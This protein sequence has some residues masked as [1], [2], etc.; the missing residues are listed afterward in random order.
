VPATAAPGSTIAI[1]ASAVDTRG[2]VSS[3]QTINVTVLDGTPPSVSITGVTTGERVRPGQEVTA[4]VSAGDAG[5]IATIGFSASGAAPR[6][7][8]RGRADSTTFIRTSVIYQ[9]FSPDFRVGK[10][11]Q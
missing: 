11:S 4:V 5:G 3:A 1:E 9:L 8:A 7:E 6:V 2:Q 10:L